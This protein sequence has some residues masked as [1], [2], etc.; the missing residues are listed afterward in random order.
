MT[1]QPASPMSAYRQRMRQKMAEMRGRLMETAMRKLEGGQVNPR[2]QL[3]FFAPDKSV[4]V[5]MG[6]L[7]STDVQLLNIALMQIKAVALP[8]SVLVV[9]DEAESFPEAPPPAQGA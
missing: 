2:F 6:G 1:Q 7:S 4:I 8:G 3:K 9:S 5:T